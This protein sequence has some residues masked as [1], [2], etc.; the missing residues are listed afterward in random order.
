MVA[1][2]R[3][4]LRNG[5]LV[6]PKGVFLGDV[7]IEGDKI[8]D[9]VPGGVDEAQLADAEAFDATGCWV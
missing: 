2:A 7:V 5:Q 3:K 8:A 1:Q 6:T 9:V 4:V